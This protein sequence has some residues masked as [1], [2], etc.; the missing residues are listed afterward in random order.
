MS[1]STSPHASVFAIAMLRAQNA[2]SYI[3]SL[4][5]HAIYWI[6]PENSIIESQAGQHR[7]TMSF[8]FKGTKRFSDGLI[9]PSARLKAGQKRIQHW[10]FTQRPF[11]GNPKAPPDAGPV[12]R[13]LPLGFVA[14]SCSWRGHQ[15]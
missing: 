3:T 15:T 11:Y 9:P 5:M 1:V 7:S 8:F 4:D 6:I 12:T 13:L 14:A 10:N 2:F